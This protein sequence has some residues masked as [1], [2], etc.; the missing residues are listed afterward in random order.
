[1]LMSLHLSMRLCDRLPHTPLIQV[2]MSAGQSCIHVQINW[3]SNLFTVQHLDWSYAISL[4]Y[5]CR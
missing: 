1:M 4:V 5:A 2:Y 3:G